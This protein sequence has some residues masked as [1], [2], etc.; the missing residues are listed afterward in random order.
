MSDLNGRTFVITG[1]NTGIGAV[2]ARELAARGA[3]VVLAGRSQARTQAVLDAIGPERADFI[4]LDLG[5]LASVRQAAEA[6]LALQRPLHGLN[7]NAGL[8]G[9]QGQTEDGFEVAFGVN[10]LGHYLLTRLLLDAL[11]AT[12]G[13]R[14]VNVASKAHLKAGPLDYAALTRP[15][16]TTTGLPEY[17]RSK[18]ANVLFTLALA[19]RTSVPTC[20]LHPGVV[21]TDVW[22]RVPRLIRPLLTLWMIS[23]EEGAKTTLRCTTEPIE[24]GAYYDKCAVAPMSPLATDAAARELWD[25]S[26]EWVGL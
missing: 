4:P 20:S 3:H 17:Q 10:H 14:I 21:A 15:T 7:N 25:R 22:R 18:L 6:I 1:A 23:P 26:A 5:S 16:A 11:T 24:S 13:G 2:T 19:R 8:A 9:H 12:P